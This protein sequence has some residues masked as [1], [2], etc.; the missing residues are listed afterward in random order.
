MARNNYSRFR[1]VI[2]NR[3]INNKFIAIVFIS[4]SLFLIIFTVMDSKESRKLK[5]AYGDRFKDKI[6]SYLFGRVNSNPVRCE[7]SLLLPILVTSKF[8]NFQ[9]GTF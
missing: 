5:T 6:G 3:A 9:T 1:A 4:I 8:R 7:N 2:K